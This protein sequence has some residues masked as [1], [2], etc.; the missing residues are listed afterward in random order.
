MSRQL[1]DLPL[2]VMMLVGMELKGRM[3]IVASGITTEGVEITLGLW[4]VVLRRDGTA[5]DGRWMLE[6]EKH[7]RKVSATPTCPRL[8]IAIELRL[9]LPKSNLTH[10]AAIR[11]LSDD[12]TGLSSPNFPDGRANFAIT[13]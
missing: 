3:M 1:A 11:S 2:A 5:L 12:P 6:A 8:A 7:F 13:G 9:H 4:E 10:E